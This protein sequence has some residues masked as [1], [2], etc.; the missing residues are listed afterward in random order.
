LCR[1][2]VISEAVGTV[3]TT[4]PV[5]VRQCSGR[6]SNQRRVDCKSI[7]G[8]TIPRTRAHIPVVATGVGAWQHHGPDY[9]T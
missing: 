5:G 7:T 4:C 3:W 9:K 1:T 2:V 6:E 8:T